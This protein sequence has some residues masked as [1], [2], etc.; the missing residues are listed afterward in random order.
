M[1]QKLPLSALNAALIISKQKTERDAIGKFRTSVRIA[2]DFFI[3]D[4]RSRS[5]N[6]PQII[7]IAFTNKKNQD[8]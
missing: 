4:I 3:T 7:D 2:G 6:C 8:V 1:L 5:G